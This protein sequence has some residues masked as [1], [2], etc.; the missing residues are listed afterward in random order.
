[1]AQSLNSM[2]SLGIQ[3]VL[4]ETNHKTKIPMPWPPLNFQKVFARR[5]HEPDLP[6]DSTMA[7]N[8]Q[9]KRQARKS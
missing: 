6:A 8:A 1:M 3:V 5:R 9:R 4:M 7:A 2:P